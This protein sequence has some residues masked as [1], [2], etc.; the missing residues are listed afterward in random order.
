GTY[1]TVRVN[2]MLSSAKNQPGDAFTATLTQPLVVNGVVVAEPGQ[3]V[4]GRVAIVQKHSTNKAAQLGVQLTNMTLVD[5]Q[6]VPI[7]TQ[8]ISRQGGTT[9]GGAEAGSVI[10]TTGLGAAIGAA[11]DWGTGAAIGAGAGAV[12]GLIGVVL[13]HNHP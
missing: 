9:P 1:L 13:T 11:A 8:F 7:V 3:T 12:A 4:G 2:E 6:Q 10:A 5:G